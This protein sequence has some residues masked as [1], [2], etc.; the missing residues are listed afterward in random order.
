[1]FAK[2]V[3]N[4]YLEYSGIFLFKWNLPNYLF[5]YSANM[6]WSDQGPIGVWV[7]WPVLY[8]GYLILLLTLGFDFIGF[9]KA[10]NHW[11]WFFGKDQ[12][13]RTVSPGYFKNSKN[14]R[15]SGKI[16]QRTVSSFKNKATKYVYI[17]IDI[18]THG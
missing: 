15:V 13:Q 17:C 9:S 6:C 11:L 8:G 4:I 16:W 2:K 14:W 7:F 18:C 10:K 3:K 12:I 5:I 1:M